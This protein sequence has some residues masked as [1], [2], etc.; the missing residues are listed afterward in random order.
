MV[1]RHNEVQRQETVGES[2]DGR[3]KA[4]IGEHA[5]TYYFAPVDSG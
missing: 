4:E 3:E 5:R 1:Y 2:M